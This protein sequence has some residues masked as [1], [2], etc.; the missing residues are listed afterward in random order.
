MFINFYK[1]TNQRG[2]VM[3]RLDEEEEWDNDDFDD[4]E[5]DNDEEE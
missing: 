1:I 2:I 4:E 5:W 3:T